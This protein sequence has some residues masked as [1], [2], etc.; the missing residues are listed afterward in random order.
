[1]NDH[2]YKDF[3]PFEGKIWLN[4]ASEG[5]IPHA[6]VKAI[7]EAV[8]WKVKPYQLT[9]KRFAEIP[10]R[11]KEVIAK[12]IHVKADDVILGNSATYGIH[13]LAHGLPLNKGDEILLMQND[14][15]V[16]ILPW[17]Q[18]QSKGILVRQLKPKVVVLE[19]E[20]VANNITSATKVVCLPHVHT[21]SG[22][23]LNIERIGKICQDK[24]IIFIVN[25]SQSI[26]TLPI[27]VSQLPVDALTCAGFKWL[28]G[29]YGTGF[30]WMKPELR[31]RL[32]YRQA[33]WVNVLTAAE[34]EGSGELKLSDLSGTR[35]YDVFG[36]ANFFNFCP[37]TASIEYLSSLGID[38]IYAHNN[39]AV[40][41]IIS[42]LD[43]KS[44]SLLSPRAEKDRSTLVVF[45]H[46]D[47][48]RNADI[49]KTLRAQGIFLA[50]WKGNLRASPHIFNTIKDSETFLSHLHKLA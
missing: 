39:A 40:N 27:D 24:N 45:S 11:L 7:Q 46:K 22:Y 35:Q 29:P 15:P 12:F 26:G 2:Y 4:C 23:K 31:E 41:Q 8:D 28:L 1:M 44:F 16:D 21:F 48:S 32:Q 36:T 10:R 25:F 6:A 13:L 37:W 18:L 50:L 5:A 38:T 34:L 14:F 17:L 30:C 43:S 19:P 3:G 42:G 49:W 20:E 9:N 33:F 47:K